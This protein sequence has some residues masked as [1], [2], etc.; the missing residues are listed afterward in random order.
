MRVLVRGSTYLRWVY[1]LLGAALVLA[2]ILVD[3]GLVALIGELHLHPIPA[4]ILVTLVVIAPPAVLGLLPAVRE[5]EGIAVESL[6]GV[7]FEERPLG[8]ARTWP[9]RRRTAAWFLIHLIAG[10]F[11]GTLDNQAIAS[12]NAGFATVGTDTGHTGNVVDAS[13]ALNNVER[14]VN[15]GHVAV[16]RTAVVSKAIVRGSVD[17]EKPTLPHMDR[18]GGSPPVKASR[19]VWWRDGFAATD[20]YEMDD[21]QRGH[22]IEG[23]AVL[24][25]ESTTFPIPPDR[26]AWLD[27]HGIFHLEHKT[28]AE[29]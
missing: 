6:L 3:S 23:P 29:S 5:V 11:V 7:R 15:F 8:P 21:V 14:R 28:S 16:H 22:V 13:W 1:L 9:Q 26:R 10:G 24:E 18:V 4:G 27:E 12:V 17:I 25:A 20:V 19:D 2:F